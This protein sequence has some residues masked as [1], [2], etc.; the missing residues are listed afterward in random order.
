MKITS[1]MA[2]EMTEKAI[3][4]HKAL[5]A[6]NVDRCLYELI[7]PAITKKAQGCFKEVRVDVTAIEKFGGKEV[8]NGVSREIHDAGFK[9]GYTANNSALLIEW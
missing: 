8:L 1:V 2:Q 5:V 9:V 3:A 4:T 6:E 7:E